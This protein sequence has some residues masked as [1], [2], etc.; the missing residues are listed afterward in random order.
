MIN[1]KLEETITIQQVEKFIREI[2]YVAV[3]MNLSNSIK[4]F[5]CE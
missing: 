1:P 5:N 3:D 2:A 4:R